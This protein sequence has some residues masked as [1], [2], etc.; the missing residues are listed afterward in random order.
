MF[1]KME[2]RHDS[3]VT[4]FSEAVSREHTAKLSLL[5]SDTRYLL[6]HY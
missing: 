1:M 3:N 5:L 6:V 4:F 2:I